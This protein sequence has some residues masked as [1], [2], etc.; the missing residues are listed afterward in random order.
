MVCPSMVTAGAHGHCCRRDYS[1]L[2]TPG[3]T[4]WIFRRSVY[5]YVLQMTVSLRTYLVGVF[6]AQRAIMLRARRG[7]LAATTA[8]DIRAD[9]DRRVG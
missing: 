3:P 4:G 2:P 6:K 9:T 1:Y 8:T 7:W 5:M